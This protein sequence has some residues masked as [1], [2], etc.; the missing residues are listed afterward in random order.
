MSSIHSSTDLKGV[1]TLTLSR[2]ERHNALNRKFIDEFKASLDSVEGSTRVLIIAAEGDSFCA[3]GD[4]QWMRDSVNLTAEQNQADAMALSNLLDTLNRF[5]APV[6]ARVQ[7]AALGGGAGLVCC[8]DI[9]VASEDAIFAFSEVRL[10]IIPATISPYALS[11]I[12][13]RAAR[14][15][16]LTG[17]RFDALCA[18]RLGL[19]H[20]V[21]SSDNL[22]NRIKDI[23]D[24]LLASGSVAQKSCK[25]LIADIAAQPITDSM[26]EE[27][28]QRLAEVRASDE[29]QE[30]LQAFLEKRKPSWQSS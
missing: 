6:I 26:R 30:G 11:A 10:G 27:L 20:D 4:I 25:R 12:G 2:P 17:E 15:Y 18:Y 19:V 21:C 28:G 16:F 7:G 9:V 13:A 22:N 8:C 29:G 1:T 14:R 23:L 3:G 5:P 24:R